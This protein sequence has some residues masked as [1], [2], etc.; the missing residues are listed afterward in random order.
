VPKCSICISP[1]REKIDIALASGASVRNI[2]KQFNVGVSS[3]HR[4][5]ADGHIC[6]AIEAAANEKEVQTGLNISK[7]VQEIYEIATGSAKDAREAKQFGAV[8][9]CLNSAAKVLEVLSKG[10]PDKT[11]ETPKESGFMAGYM[12]RA[13]EVYGKDQSPPS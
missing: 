1:F 6:K 4:H 5:K 10:N 2:A 12:K 7:C 13:G 9:S 11:P 8:G 3:V